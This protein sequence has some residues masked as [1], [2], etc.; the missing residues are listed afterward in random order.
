VNPTLTVLVYSSIAAA[1]AALGIV[2]FAVRGR[3]VP[4]NWVGWANALAAGLMLG[5]IFGIADV[6]LDSSLL[7]AVAG[8]LVGI[9]FIYWTH[10]ISR[11]VDLDL[12]RLEDTPPEYGYQVLLVQSL[13]AASEGVAM[14]VAMSI[15]LQLGIFTALAL[16]IHNVPE[17]AV[18]CA[19]LVSRRIRLRD[20][21]G[22]AVVSNLGQVLLALSTFA[23]VSAMPVLL[24]W[25]VGFVMGALVYLVMSELLPQSYSQAGNTSIALLTSVA[26]GVVVL[27]NGFLL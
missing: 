6:G 9:G 22:L 25:T 26:M 10:L 12:N 13:H 15:S 27:L 20:A 11:S 19:V 14:G 7:A 3:P 16:A 18:L 24:P 4:L 8:A 21:S 1:A 2:P 17:A 23:V 5:A